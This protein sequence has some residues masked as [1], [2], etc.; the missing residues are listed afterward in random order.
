MYSD[1]IGHKLGDRIVFPAAGYL[2]Q[3]WS[4]YATILGRKW[5][6][7]PVQMS[8][9][10]LNRAT[11]LSEQ[12]VARL[13]TKILPGL[14]KF[15]FENEGDTVVSGNIKE[16]TGKLPTVEDVELAL[17]SLEP[18]QYIPLSMNDIYKEFRL[19][20]YNYTGLFKGIHKIDNEGMYRIIRLH[21]PP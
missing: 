7:V 4:T 3:A 21:A 18:S 19:R 16:L 13:K 1:L 6:T 17:S 14:G 8:N 5:D 15:E 2:V 10:V 20:G 9:V 11:V 12:G